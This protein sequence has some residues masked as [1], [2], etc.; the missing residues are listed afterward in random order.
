[1]SLLPIIYTSVLIFC[2]LVTVVLVVSY[3]MYKMKGG[4]PKPAIVPANEPVNYSRQRN[5]ITVNKVYSV[6]NGYS[7]KKYGTNRSHEEL[8]FYK[9]PITA[10]RTSQQTRRT[11][12]PRIQII[13]KPVEKKIVV[14]RKSANYNSYDANN[15]L[16]YYNENERSVLIQA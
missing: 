9:K 14:V 16:G 3:T 8:M 7:Q 1:M 15:F 6:N 2:G 13:N 11:S 5:N 12:T 10:Q 4:G